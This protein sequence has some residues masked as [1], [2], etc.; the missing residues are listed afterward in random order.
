MSGTFTD[1]AENLVMDWINAVGTPTRPSGL[2][3]ALTT[4]VG[5]DST[6]GTEVSGGSYARQTLA[7]SA[8]SGGATANTATV[9]FAGMPSCTVQGVEIWDSAGG[10]RL[11]WASLAANK[12]VNSGDIF[13]I[14]AGSLT[15]TID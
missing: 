5:T 15:L 7:V 8:S 11:W 1:T 13:E 4:T 9:S 10:N 2:K 14:T 3:L 6:A 12:V